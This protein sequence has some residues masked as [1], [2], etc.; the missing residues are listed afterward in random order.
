MTFR[1]SLDRGQKLL[2]SFVLLICVVAPL[3]AHLSG[4]G[5]PT[6]ATTVVI[7]AAVAVAWAYSPSQVRV[8][9]DELVI[10]RRAAP[11]VRLRAADVAST[12][13]GPR[14]A[15]L[16]LCGS[17]G[18]LGSFGLF[19]TKALG[20]YWLYG[21]RSMGPSAILHRHRGLPIVLAVDDLDGLRRAL[22]A[23]RKTG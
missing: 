5:P 9:R 22:A 12:G 20:P 15:T 2:A 6:I 17:G 1:I 3:I 14:A 21:N 10:S 19:W 23:W 18:F 8:S 13:E 7:A 4:S 11:P 16:R